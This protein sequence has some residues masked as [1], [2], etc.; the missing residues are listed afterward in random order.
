[1][2]NGFSTYLSQKLI[3]V[4]L[5]GQAYTPPTNLFLALFTADPTDGNVTA[6]EVSALAWTTYA[7]QA[8]GAWAAA[9]GA[10]GNMTSN[11]NPVQ[12]PAVAGNAVTV[13][14]WGIYDA[15]TGGNLLY[16]GAITGG[17]K[18]LNVG[19]VLTVSA[20]DLEITLD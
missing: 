19:D 7:R 11:S 1:M 4:T 18:T 2:A 6:N 20:G 16:S 12:F 3:D 9:G 14:H 15:S 17:S 13:S 10:G 8:T 5:R